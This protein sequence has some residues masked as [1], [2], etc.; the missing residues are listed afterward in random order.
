MNWIFE[1]YGETYKA[2]TMQDSGQLNKIYVMAGP[3]P[4]LSSP[5]ADARIKSAHDEPPCQD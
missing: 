4:A 3:D 1:I 5:M 2:L